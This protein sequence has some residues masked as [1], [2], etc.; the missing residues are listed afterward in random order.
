[1]RPTDACRVTVI[2]PTCDR[3]VGLTFA[4][5]WMRRQTR[6]PDEWIVSDGGEVPAP[7]RMG[8]RQIHVPQLPGARN[9]VE[10]LRRA[11]DVATGDVIVLWED[12][13]WYAPTH[14]ERLLVQLA[15]P[16]VLAAGD[17]K[18]RYYHVGARRWH[19][20]QNRGAALCQ[21]GFRRELVPLFREILDRCLAVDHYGIDSRFW[22]ALSPDQKQ[23]AHTATV[24]GI[25]GLPGRRGLG[26]GHRPE[27]IKQWTPDPALGQ[28]R[29]WIGADAEAYAACA[30][31][32]A[33]AAARLPVVVSA[34]LP[35]PV[36]RS[37]GRRPQLHAVYFGID[38]Q[39]ARLARVLEYSAHQHCPGWDIDVRAITP[40]PCHPPAR[41]AAHAAYVA[42][43][44]KL[45]EWTRLVDQAPDGD[46]LALLDADTMVLRTLDAVWDQ[47][48][49]VAYTVRT[50]SRFPINAGV[51]FVRVSDRTRAFMAAWRDENHRQLGDPARH[52]RWRRQYGGMNQA[53]L[54][55]LLEQRGGPDVKFLRLPCVE[56]N[57]E[58]SAWPAVDRA[59]TRIVHLKSGLR[60]ALFHGTSA[61]SLL[62]LVHIW[63]TFERAAAGLAA[64]SPPLAR[65]AHAPHRSLPSRPFLVR[66]PRG[67]PRGAGTI[68]VNV[69]LTPD[70][71]DA[72]CRKAHAS[73][74]PLHAL[75]QEVL[76]TKAP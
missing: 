4:E 41:T 24:V 50:S 57:A 13:D 49:D 20:Y 51:I 1:M 5:R 18:Q 27:I 76:T 29:R 36:P 23:L 7:C 45:D 74:R 32:V 48:F 64:I 54:G 6:P 25:K 12:D 73:D 22:G 46:R 71:Y 37:G 21:T 11:L 55:A 53:A 39:W 65:P 43:T 35:P 66:R 75:F 26:V 28:L 3:P 62:A 14:L 34:A 30:G 59:R 40:A 70:V 61:R 56:W 16:R 31:D 2:T 60:R 9:L 10:N 19:V 33:A 52:Q 42:N 68:K 17:N 38:P 67:R 15:T 44:Q 69:R 63:R 72:Y 47:V 8:Q 58:E